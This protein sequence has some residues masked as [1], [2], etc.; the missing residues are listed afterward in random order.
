MAYKYAM[1]Y[2]ANGDARHARQALAII[3]GWVRTNK[4]FGL[5]GKN[6]PLEAGWCAHS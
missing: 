6:G 2:A 3:A 1:A 4:V 5:K